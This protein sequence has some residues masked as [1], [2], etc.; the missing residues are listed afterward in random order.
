[1]SSEGAIEN[2]RTLPLESDNLT[3]DMSLASAV[4]SGAL[5]PTF[6]SGPSKGQ[7]VALKG[8]DFFAFPSV[9]PSKFVYIEPLFVN[10]YSPEQRCCQIGSE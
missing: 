1:M 3:G 7:G 4:K 2:R 9:I 10:S 5:S 6:S 8:D